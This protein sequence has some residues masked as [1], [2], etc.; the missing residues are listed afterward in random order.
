MPY[1]TPVDIWSCG[2]I[3]AELFLGAP[4]FEGQ[5]E[6]DQLNKIFNV[7]G[8][9]SEEEWPAESAVQRSNF[10]P[11]PPRELASCMPHL[12]ADQEDLM[13]VSAKNRTFL[14]FLY[15]DWQ[16]L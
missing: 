11:R 13:K 9:P 3:F 8:L 1:A 7:M 10:S 14:Y 2:C 15:F 5:Y 12:E 16:P 4:F 6:M